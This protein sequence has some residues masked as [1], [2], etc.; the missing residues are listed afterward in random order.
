MPKV[1]V[2]GVG[3]IAD[4]AFSY[5]QADSPYEIV[6]FVVDRGFRNID[7]FNGCPVVEFES[8]EEVFPPGDHYFF[9]PMSYRGMNKNRE[10]VFEEAKGKGYE[11]ISYISSKAISWAEQIGEN[12]FILEANVLQPR[13]TIG[14][15]VVLWSGNHIGHHTKVA[16]S[17]FIASHV[18]VSGNVR[19]G[20]R[21]FCGGNATVRD[22][23]CVG[24]EN[25]IGAGTL[26]MSD[27]EDKAVYYSKGA[28][29]SKVSSD[30]VR[31]L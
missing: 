15:N 20:E 8:V 17:C 2:F 14:D 27:T 28:S 12:C 18:V 9:A 10:R 23:V 26:I 19:I 4:V 24:V 5:L 29:P 21:T 1:I 16:D 13:V 6:A 30:R 11:F 22:N 7:E 3:Q 25:I 31:G